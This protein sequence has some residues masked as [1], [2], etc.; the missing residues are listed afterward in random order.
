MKDE[1]TQLIR[2]LEQ[3][4]YD[5]MIA[6][7]ITALDGLLAP[8]LIYTHSNGE[9][10]SKGSYLERVQ[11]AHFL[12]HSISHRVEEVIVYPQTVIVTGVMQADVTVAGQRRQLNNNNLAVW[13]SSEGRW[14]LSAYQPTPVSH[15]ATPGAPASM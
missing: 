4:R 8:E 7:D 9:R 12:Y 1:V 3:A 15:S 2:T 6:A 14:R 11:G 10:D 5:A 13:T